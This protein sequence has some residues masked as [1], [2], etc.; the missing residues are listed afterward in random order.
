LRAQNVG[1][2]E[3]SQIYKA[4]AKRFFS[5]PLSFLLPLRLN[6]QAAPEGGR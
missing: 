3:R 6:Q 1:H 4:L 5:R 2:V